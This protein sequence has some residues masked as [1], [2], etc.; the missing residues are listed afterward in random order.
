MKNIINFSYHLASK[1]ENTIQLCDVIKME[2]LTYGLP[3]LEGQG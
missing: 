3:F 2:I 1:M